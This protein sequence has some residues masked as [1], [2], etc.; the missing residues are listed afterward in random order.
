MCVYLGLQLK[1]KGRWSSIIRFRHPST[2]RLSN[3]SNKFYQPHLLGQC[4]LAFGDPEQVS[5]MDGL[6]QR[7]SALVLDGETMSWLC[8]IFYLFYI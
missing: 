6:K 2:T 5:D 3:R 7:L 1:S 8:A 4:E